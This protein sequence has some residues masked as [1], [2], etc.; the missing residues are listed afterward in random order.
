M[1]AKFDARLIVCNRNVNV[2]PVTQS[3]VR[4]SYLEVGKPDSYRDED[5]RFLTVDQFGFA[6]GVVGIINRERVSS[7][8]LIGGFWAESL[9]FAEAGNNAGCIQVAGTDQIAQIPFFICA[10]DY[11]LIGEEIYAASAYLTQD[12]IRIATLVAQDWGKR[13]VVVIILAGVITSTISSITG[14]TDHLVNQLL[15]LY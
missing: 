14:A 1:I 7:M 9:I 15:R 6:A 4:Q 3:I 5:I 8:L 11:C 12:K 2:Y 13:V 10:C